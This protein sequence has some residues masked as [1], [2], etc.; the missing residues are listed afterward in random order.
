MK[1]RGLSRTDLPLCQLNNK[2]QRRSTILNSWS[3]LVMRA[4]FFGGKRKLHVNKITRKNYTM[5]RERFC[6]DIL[7]NNDFSWS[8]GP[9]SCQ[10]I[11]CGNPPYVPNADVLLTGKQA[12]GTSA[13]GDLANYTC[14]GG[15][16]LLANTTKGPVSSI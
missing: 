2:R 16:L 8:A 1:S 10:P 7:Q 14:S 5:N 15:F 9:P 3:T 4:M 11:S 13:V 12:S 6:S